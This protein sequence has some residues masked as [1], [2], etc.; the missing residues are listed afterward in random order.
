MEK[1]QKLRGP[2]EHTK[3]LFFLLFTTNSRISNYGLVA[4]CGLFT[5]YGLFWKTLLQT[6]ACIFVNCLLIKKSF[7]NMLV[8]F[9]FLYNY[10]S[11]TKLVQQSVYYKFVF[12]IFF[13]FL[14][15]FVITFYMIVI[16]SKLHKKMKTHQIQVFVLLFLFRVFSRILFFLSMKNLQQ[17]FFNFQ[18]FKTNA[19]SKFKILE[20]N[21]VCFKLNVFF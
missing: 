14:T 9:V 19:H 8:S 20:K 6:F 16:K 18:T 4:P 11:R 5:A 2:E 12:T 3:D 21:F 15:L 13:I 7:V 17:S 1:F 10:R